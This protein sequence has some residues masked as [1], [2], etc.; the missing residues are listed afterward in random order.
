M[1]AR[2]L[3]RERER[4]R[5]TERERQRKRRRGG[6]CGWVHVIFRERERERQREREREK[7]EHVIFLSPNGWAPYLR[8]LIGPEKSSNLSGTGWTCCRKYDRTVYA[9]TVNRVHCRHTGRNCIR[10]GDEHFQKN[11]IGVQCNRKQEC[12]GNDTI[13]YSPGEK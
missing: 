8:H 11:D 5:E 7:R 9:G 13:G 6:V 12:S 1:G 4:E 3:P 10:S 2:N